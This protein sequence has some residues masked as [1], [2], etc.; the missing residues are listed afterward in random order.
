MRVP[1][2]A[3]VV[4]ADG[5]RMLLLRNRGDEEFP[6]LEVEQVEEKENPATR[7]QGSDEPGSTFSSGGNP[8]GGAGQLTGSQNRSAYSQTS[9]LR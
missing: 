9:T 1:S 8:R 5:R 4:V 3:L 7:D 2:D 6:N